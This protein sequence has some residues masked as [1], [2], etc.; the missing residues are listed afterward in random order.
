MGPPEPETDAGFKAP[1]PRP[2]EGGGVTAPVPPGSR[3]GGKGSRFQSRRAR[4]VLGL[5]GGLMALLCLGGVGAFIVLY[6]E[7]TE[8]KRT[9]PDAVVDSYLAA[10]LVSRN[11]QETALYQCKSGGDLNQIVQFRD[12]TISREKE[13]SVKIAIT[14]S[15]LDVNVNGGSG[16]VGADLTRTVTGQGRDSSTWQFAVV[17]QGGWRV[18][19]ARRID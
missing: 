19:G 12:D 5:A 14:W 3:P 2:S 18:C 9:E 13:F 4:L 16:T 15:S 17:D 6:D 8:I 11:D 10:F 1:A 7:A